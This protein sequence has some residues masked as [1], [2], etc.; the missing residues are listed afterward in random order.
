MRFSFGCLLLC[1]AVALTG[2]SPSDSGDGNTT[3]SQKP[4]APSTQSTAEAVKSPAQATPDAAVTNFLKALKAGDDSLATSMLT[5]KAQAEM[6]RTESA[7]KPPGSPTATFNVS[8]VE[9]L[10]EQKTGAHV[11]CTWTDKDEAGADKTYEI[12]WILRDEAAGWSIAG[13][14]T[15]VFDDQDPLILNFEDPLDAQRK[16]QAVDQEMARRNGQNE[17]VQQAQRPQ[18]NR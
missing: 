15:R 8:E 2:C 10:G 3:T 16:R 11:L 1:L 9:F 6:E 14:A 7:I 17:P 12:V 5:K 18:M 4:A 13:M